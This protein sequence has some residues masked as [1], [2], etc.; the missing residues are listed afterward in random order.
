M[1][2]ELSDISSDGPDRERLEE[3]GRSLSD[4]RPVPTP[5]FRGELGRLIGAAQL[6]RAVTHWRAKALAVALAG[7]LLLG[8]AGAGVAGSGPLAPSHLSGAPVSS[9]PHAR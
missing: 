1:S 6:I 4:A 2:D 8:V 7:A 9:A 3:T 5:A